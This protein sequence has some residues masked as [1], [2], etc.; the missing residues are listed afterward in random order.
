M[1]SRPPASVMLFDISTRDVCD[2]KKEK[3]YVKWRKTL[4]K[5]HFELHCKLRWI[6]WVQWSF[7]LS[8]VKAMEERVWGEVCECYVFKGFTY[9]CCDIRQSLP[10]CSV[11]CVHGSAPNLEETTH[12]ICHGPPR[13]LQ[14][15]QRYSVCFFLSVLSPFSINK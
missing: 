8:P 15:A 13:L 12:N 6:I 5:V 7:S 11:W 9:K 3:M 2:T 1:S 10:L 4:S 14:Q